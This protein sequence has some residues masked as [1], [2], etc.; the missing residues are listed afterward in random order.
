MPQPRELT[1]R[2]RL[3]RIL[4]SSRSGTV[5]GATDLASG[6]PVAIK[7]IAAGAAAGLSGA[8]QRLARLA[9]VL[10][11]LAHPNLPAA[12]DSGFTP[13]GSAFLVL[14]LLAGE[15]FETLA[16]APPE[17]IL[18]LLGQALAALE[19]LAEHGLAHHNLSP[20]NL[21]LTAADGGPGLKLLGLG[22]GLLPAAH[23]GGGGESSRYCAPELSASAASGAAAADWRADLYSLA[24][25]ACHALGATV[26]FRG[27]DGPLVQMPLALSFALEN[28]EALRRILERCLRQEPAQRPSHRQVREAFDLA[29]GAAAPP[30]WRDE[31]NPPAFSPLRAGGLPEGGWAGAEPADLAEL[32]ALPELPELPEPAPAIEVIERTPPPGAGAAVPPGRETGPSADGSALLSSATDLQLPATLP[33]LPDETPIP[34]A[35]AQPTAPAPPDAPAAPATPVRPSP[36]VQAHAPTAPAP[37]G[38]M[39]AATA[40]PTPAAAGAA[41][42]LAPPPVISSNAGTGVLPE[43]EPS[44]PVEVLR[45]IDDELLN[46]LPPPGPGPLPGRAAAPP[47]GRL[48]SASGW[49]ARAADRLGAGSFRSLALRLGRLPRAVLLG[50]AAAA[51][52][53]LG[54]LGLFLLIGRRSAATAG[55]A[56]PP[57]PVLAAAAAPPGMSPLEKLAAVKGYLA[58]GKESHFKVR[59]ALRALSPQDRAALPPRACKELLAIEETLAL[60]ALESLPQDLAN[61]LK[62]GDLALLEGAVAA[63]GERGLPP[64]LQPDFAR[65]H[66]LV[67]LYGLARAA[68]EK[69]DHAEVLKRFRAMGASSSSLR[70]PLALRDKAAAALEAAAADLARD[71]NYDEAL[72]RLATVRRT[73]PSRA[74]IAELESSYEGSRSAEREQEDLLAR[75]AAFERRR[76]PGEALDRLQNVKPTPHLAARFAE[77]RA[78]LQGQ[79]AAL[80]QQPPQV[81]LRPG[82]PLDYARGQVVTL[83]FRATDDY[84][85]RSVRLFARP[86]RG[87]LRELPLRKDG[88]GY[89]VV[90]PPSFHRN[91]TVDFYVVAAD[92]SGHEGTLG[93]K[94]QPLHLKRRQGFERMLR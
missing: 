13:D 72:A 30:I 39:A 38:A 47:P 17:R 59:E 52:V 49:T 64:A 87:R 55:A 78:R 29:L 15:S 76:K 65:A 18:P 88:L 10:G 14:E 60:A 33:D 27:A 63:G 25:T 94:D 92:L 91:G 11:S 57:A 4:S 74:G 89:T 34:V 77:A 26:V 56:A 86:E 70:D 93:T 73:W 37:P 84:Q 46:A 23:L 58:E 68:A 45:A 71:G 24:L 61:G 5:L 16:G 2:Y 6:R 12:F 80:D 79:L 31:T 51:V 9:D 81:T 48:Q 42:S 85:V 7:L 90:I 43:A 40:T 50:G 62:T 69:N 21:Y 44:E 54:A 67:A 35:A 20:D 82:Y 83:S 3:E 32:G 53:L 8:E 66:N 41:V 1:D 19:A 75:L 22:S 28:D 36:A